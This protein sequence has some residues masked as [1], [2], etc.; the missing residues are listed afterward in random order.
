MFPVLSDLTRDERQDEV[1]GL[2]QVVVARQGVLGQR[3]V[4]AWSR[5][6]GHRCSHSGSHH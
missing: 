3:E 1:D 5:H 4:L 6:A 2:K